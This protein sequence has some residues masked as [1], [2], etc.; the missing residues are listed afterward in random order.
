MV[1][2]LVAL[3]VMAVVITMSMAL[4]SVPSCPT[5]DGFDGTG[6][7]CVWTDP[8]TGKRYYNDGK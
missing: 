5:E 7:A 1:G 3:S 8:D 6:K 4:K 2:S